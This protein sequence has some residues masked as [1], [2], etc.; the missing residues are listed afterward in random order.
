[1]LILEDFCRGL[2]VVEQLVDF[3]NLLP[4]HGLFSLNSAQQ[5]G[6]RKQLNSVPEGKTGS[7]SHSV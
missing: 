3:L 4:L 7:K 5:T 1:M 2:G 6:R